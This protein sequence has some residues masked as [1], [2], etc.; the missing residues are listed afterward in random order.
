MSFSEVVWTNVQSPL[1]RPAFESSGCR[2][3]LGIRG[4]PVLRHIASVRSRLQLP[5]RR[6]REGQL[7]PALG[8]GSAHAYRTG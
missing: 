8:V 7:L 1:H 6:W 3:S 5:M 2:V 4:V